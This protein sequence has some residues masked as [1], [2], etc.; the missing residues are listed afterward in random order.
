MGWII[1]RVSN[2]TRVPITDRQAA[3]LRAFRRLLLVGFGL[4]TKYDIVVENYGD[5]E[6]ALREIALDVALH[7]IMPEWGTACLSLLN[8][9]VTNLLAAGMLYVEHVPN[10]VAR[11]YARK[12]PAIIEA[13]K[14]RQQEVESDSLGLRAMR[15]L[16]NHTLHH[17]LPVQAMDGDS[18]AK[19]VVPLLELDRLEADRDFDR[20]ILREIALGRVGKRAKL[21]PLA[22]SFVQSISDIHGAVRDALAPDIEE[23][24]NALVEVARLVEPSYALGHPDVAFHVWEENGEDSFVTT[25]FLLSRYR[26]FVARNRSLDLRREFGEWGITVSSSAE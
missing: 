20:E 14:K 15:A 23:G 9:R 21:T 11:L 12:K 10:D 8:R 17:E 6:R 16:R 5:Y 25:T 2:D 24:T 13:L 22:R 7:G 1:R 26:S 4:E 3:A 18:V 19:G